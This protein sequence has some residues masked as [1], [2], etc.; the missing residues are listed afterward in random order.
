VPSGENG[1]KEKEMAKARSCIE[2]L[3]AVLLILGALIGLGR[4]IDAYP[5][6]VVLSYQVISVAALVLVVLLLIFLGP[7]RRG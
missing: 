6:A 1:D 5:A 7:R 3:V 2:L 4:A